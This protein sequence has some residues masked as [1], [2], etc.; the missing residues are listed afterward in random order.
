MYNFMVEDAIMRL[1]EHEAENLKNLLE[2]AVEIAEVVEFINKSKGRII[3]TGLGKSGYAGRKIAATLSSIGRASIFI[4]PT[5]ALHGDIGVINHDDIAICIS[6]S[7]ET[8]EMKELMQAFK[9]HGIKTVA[10]TSDTDSTLAGLCDRSITLPT[11]TEGDPLGMVPTTS[12]I[13]TIAIGDAI[14]TGLMIIDGV[15]CD[16]FRIYHPGGIL[17]TKL[18]RVG[19]LM[20]TGEELPIVR[21]DA[22]L[23]E[24]ILMISEKKLGVAV[25][26]DDDDNLIGILTDGDIRRAIQSEDFA[27]PLLENVLHFVTKNPMT[28]TTCQIIEEALHIMEEK[29]ITSLVVCEKAKVLGIIHM[30][31]VLQQRII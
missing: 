27:Q 2:S 3:I 15:D 22:T 13:L 30:H 5:E 25:I 29:K 9:L 11:D 10:I 18:M 31:D 4:H 20:H 28:I 12:I 21:Q 17:G 14:A 23:K 6:K 16:R 1:I 8:K 19:D 26:A 7:G 24:A